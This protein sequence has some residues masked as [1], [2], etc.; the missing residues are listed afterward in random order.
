MAAHAKIVKEGSLDSLEPVDATCPSCGAMARINLTDLFV[1]QFKDNKGTPPTQERLLRMAQKI[2]DQGPPA[3]AGKEEETKAAALE[4]AKHSAL[5]TA[6][7]W[8][9]SC[10]TVVRLTTPPRGTSWSSSSPTNSGRKRDDSI[11]SQR[12]NGDTSSLRGSRG[13]SLDADEE[14]F[15]PE[16]TVFLLLL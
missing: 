5:N 6:V 8:R 15:P 11:I 14:L 16:A 9:C 10:E 2:L 7:A 4:K 13:V 1:Y 3:Q 12:N